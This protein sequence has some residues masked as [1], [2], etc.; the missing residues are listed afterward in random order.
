MKTG[1][2][3]C[4]LAVVV[5]MIA[6]GTFAFGA[7][8]P[9]AYRPLIAG[10]LAVGLLTLAAMRT[11]PRG[12]TLDRWLAAAFASFGVAAAGQL[13]PLQLGTLRRFAA[14]TARALA[15][16]NPA[17]ASGA[18]GRHAL[19]IA[20]Q[21]TVVGICLFAACAIVALATSRLFTLRGARGFARAL[22]ILGA[23]VAMAGIVQQPLFNGR[24]YGFWA[25][26]DG[27]SPYGPFVN[28]NHFAG[29]MLMT[30]PV[31]LGLLLGGI[32]RAMRGVPPRWRDRL[33]WFS[34]AEAS[35]LIL[36]GAAALVMALALVLTM[37]R[38]GVASLAVAMAITSAFV[39]RRRWTGGRAR[40]AFAYL[41]FLIVVVS[42]WVGA[43][44]IASRFS[45]TDWADVNARRG[46]WADAADIRARFP[47]AGTGLNTYGV[48]TILYQRHDTSR[49]YTEAHN[50]YLQLAAEGGWLLTVPAI[51]CVFVFAVAVKR[52][53][54]KETSASAFWLRVGAVTGIAAI[55]IQETVE[56][57]LQM[58]GNAVLFAALCGIALHKAPVR[59]A[60]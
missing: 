41:L 30:L 47:Y 53:F 8:Y 12:T 34:S 18:V 7:V 4:A 56:F 48:A 58:P 24:I 50:D 51:A 46:A 21:E 20:P 36:I 25:T 15:Q 13:L 54:V 39:V 5:A 6:W 28:K 45:N 42:S 3:R 31:T 19:S 59:R 37:S 29:W 11:A 43:D 49:R 17:V 9:W 16:I 38:S 52:R 33:V 1:T 10:A 27:G 23:L 57:S 22:A 26:I 35:H 2:A 44:A 55:A 60:I 14:E 32:A 40:V